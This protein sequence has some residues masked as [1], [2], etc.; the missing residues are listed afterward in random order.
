MHSL[1]TISRDFPDIPVF[2]VFQPPDK[3]RSIYTRMLANVPRIIGESGHYKDIQFFDLEKIWQEH[4]DFPGSLVDPVH[5][6]NEGHSI[7]A[8]YLSEYLYPIV[9]ERCSR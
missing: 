4:N 3:A 2:A 1:E 9:R 5:L 7:V 8:N 6:S